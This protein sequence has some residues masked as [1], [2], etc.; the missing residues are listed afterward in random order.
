MPNRASDRLLQFGLPCCGIGQGDACCT[1][2]QMRLAPSLDGAMPQMVQCSIP[3][4]LQ[5][6]A[7]HRLGHIEVLAPTPELEHH[8][9]RDF[10]G[11]RTLVQHRFRDAHKQCIVRAEDR[12]ERRAVTAP[13]PGEQL[14]L[15]YSGNSR[16]DNRDSAGALY[17]PEDIVCSDKGTPTLACLLHNPMTPDATRSDNPDT[18]VDWEAM[19]RYL[20]GE[21]DASE[22][23]RIARYLADHPGDAK[24]VSEL[25]SAMRILALHQEPE[26]DVESALQRVHARLEAP[27]SGAIPITGRPVTRPSGWRTIARSWRIVSL[28]AAA[29]VVVLAARAVLQQKGGVRGASAA[30]GARTFAT[31][32]GRIDSLRLP[33]GGRAI[34]GPASR[35][36][37]AQGYGDRVREVELHGEAYFD[38]VHDTTHPFMVR[39]A[40]ATVRDV[41]T[42]FGVREDGAQVRVVVTSGSVLLR[43]DSGV[44]RQDVLRA[45]DVATLEADGRLL[46]ERGVPTSDYLSWMTGS[47]DYRDAP[48]AEVSGDL[49]RWYG[50]VLR[51]D[52][53]T[54]AR[55][56]LKA[57]F[58]GDPIDRVLR[59]IEL[60]LGADVEL[61]GD[62]AILR[63]RTQ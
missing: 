4:C 53:S 1:L 15:L 34:L 14:A 31:A 25:D 9:L 11:R 3:G 56:H 2:R 27:S 47:L 23:E 8:V 28:L 6:V 40:S 43:S 16:H 33:D 60:D 39:V 54:L 30:A 24:V 13:E 42:A 52:D 26:V 36:T 37:I 17:T 55:K 61:R 49:R 44:R 51:V 59:V 21:S 20:A 19:A 7:S 62:T 45:G 12:I 5:H 50:V 63:P 46:T 10:L 41:G 58:N 57:T 38:V 22:R 18:P 32:V 48:L 29:A 35:L